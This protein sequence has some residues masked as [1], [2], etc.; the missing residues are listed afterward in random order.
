[1]CSVPP[2]RLV[3]DLRVIGFGGS[4]RSRNAQWDSSPVI[5][6]PYHQCSTA[7]DIYLFGEQCVVCVNPSKLC[8]MKLQASVATFVYLYLTAFNIM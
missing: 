5:L 4:I 8:C 1:M 3:S 2:V 7:E 6:K